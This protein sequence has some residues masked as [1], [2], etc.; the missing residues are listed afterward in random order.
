M[1]T[2]AI[3]GINSY[4]AGSLLPKL[5]QDPDIEAIIG[6]DIMPWSGDS[7]KVTFY[8]EDVRNPGIAGLLK[9]VDTVVHL[10][11]VVQEIHDKKKSDE[12]NIEGSRN[13]FQACAAHQVGRLIYT[14][15]IAAYGSHPENPIGITEDRPLRANDDCYYSS[16]KVAVESILD[17]FSRKHPDTTLT[18][19][20]PPVVVGPNLNN[21]AVDIY[22]RKHTFAIKG[23]DPE[24]QFL[25][26]DD[27]GE[28]L[29]IAVKQ[30]LPGEFNLAPDDYS[31]TRK[32]NEIAGMKTFDI[33]L[34]LMRFI[35]NLTFALRLGTISD[36]WVSL[37]EYPVVVSNAKFKQATGWKPKYSTE[38][39]F[40]EFIGAVKERINERK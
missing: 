25:H 13:V 26:E 9:K 15:S 29:Y 23:R 14:S 32:I 21:F 31:T 6:I 3:T 39:S 1:S 18:R 10:A 5:E 7:R 11:F 16:N 33:S 2:I 28:A 17:E 36:D 40:R 37:M 24:L 8:Q 12:I 34:G 19:F 20:R 30:D 22:S 35:A 27:L 4:F 38:A